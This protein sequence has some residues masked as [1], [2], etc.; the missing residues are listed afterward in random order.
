MQNYGTFDSTFDRTFRVVKGA[1]VDDRD[2]NKT[3]VVLDVSPYL[4][5]LFDIDPVG[6]MIS[7]KEIDVK[8]EISGA[9]MQFSVVTI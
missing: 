5:A 3:K 1:F 2:S 8:I 9:N 6:E 4:Q 7:S